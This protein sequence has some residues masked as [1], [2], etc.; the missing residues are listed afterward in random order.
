MSED[1]QHLL[2][3]LKKDGVEKAEEA[4]EKIISDARVKADEIISDAKKEAEQIIAQAKADAQKFEERSKQALEQA[5]RNVVQSLGKDIEKLFNECLREEVGTAFDPETL[6]KILL[7]VSELYFDC[8]VFEGPAD[9]ELSPEDHKALVNFINEKMREKF[10]K[11][12]GIRSD[13]RIRKGFRISLRDKDLYHDFTQDA[14][15]DELSDYLRPE[16]Q[17]IVR[18]VTDESDKSGKES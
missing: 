12:V 16:M 5:S 2:E 9:V 4:S 7:K 17:K 15:A 11:G 8:N 6:K 3:T 14:I 10:K 18:K 1:L 13:S